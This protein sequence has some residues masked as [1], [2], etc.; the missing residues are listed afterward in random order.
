MYV[1]LTYEL[2]SGLKTPLQF[3]HMSFD[4]RPTS[5]GRPAAQGGH[6]FDYQAASTYPFPCISSAKDDTT[7]LITL[8]PPEHD[9]FFHLEAFQRR[10][11]SFSF[12]VLP[13]EVTMPEVERFLED[14]EQNAALHPDMLALLFTTL[15]LGLQ[16]GIHDK[17]DGNWTTGAIEAERKKGDL[18]S[19]CSF[20]LCM[21]A[22]H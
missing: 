3:H 11:L 18:Y 17:F 8:L 22:Y 12:P 15:A 1:D 21:D 13:E 5:L 10:S 6:Q 4:R 16:D 2:V 19:R 7:A 20:H 14:I 9:L